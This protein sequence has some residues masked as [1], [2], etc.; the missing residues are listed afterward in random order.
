MTVT[1]PSVEQPKP[2]VEQ[3]KPRMVT[4]TMPIVSL[5]VELAQAALGGVVAGLGTFVGVLTQTTAGNIKSL[6]SAAIG[7]GFVAI[8]SF[9]TSVKA[10]YN[11]KYGSVS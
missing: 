5:P 11:Q 6:E 1:P 3:P 2:S 7:A 9:A 10:W 8:T 4:L